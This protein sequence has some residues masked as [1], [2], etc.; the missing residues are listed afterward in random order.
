MEHTAQR[1]IGRIL[2]DGQF[3]SQQMLDSALE[4][5]K[6]T[7][8]LLGQVLVRMGVITAEDVGIP[9]LAQQHL[10]T[11][12]DAVKIA[13]GERQLLG[14]LLVESGWITSEELDRAIA[15]QRRSGEK[16]GEVFKRLGILSGQQLNA[17][18]DFQHSQEIINDSPFRLGELLVATGQITREQLE[19]ALNQQRITHHKLGEIL[20]EAGYVNSKRINY[21]IRLQKMVMKAVLVAILAFEAVT[22]NYASASDHL[23][24]SPQAMMK[25]ALEESGEFSCLSDKEEEL[26]RLVNEYRE[27]NGLA[28]IA[29]SR[30]LNKVARVHAIDLS[31]NIPAV[32]QDS[33]GLTCSLHSWSD[34]GDWKPVCY[35]KDNVYAEAMWD[36]PREITNFTYSGDGYENAYSTSEKEINPRKVLEAWKASPGHNAILLESGAWNGSNLLAFGVGVHEN[37]AVIWVG[38]QT[39]PLGPMQACMTATRYAMK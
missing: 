22:P 31:K 17:L 21:G 14:T 25:S 5:Q 32:G 16:L 15:E 39:D 7:K 8:E 34:K 19:N 2:L 26:F 18:L 3:V 24:S 12:S 37:Y 38:S 10:G 29:N 11:I 36:K 13:A 28:P 20:V 35:T 4:E 9:L 1:H 33:R 30:S 23:D 6:R 27:E